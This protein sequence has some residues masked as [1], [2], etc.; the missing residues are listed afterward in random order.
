MRGVS[1]PS[2]SDVKREDF[3]R[4]LVLV[5]PFVGKAEGGRRLAR[6]RIEDVRKDGRGWYTSLYRGVM[7]YRLVTACVY[8]GDKDKALMYGRNFESRVSMD[9]AFT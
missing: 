9:A 6:P 4:R 7:L 3:S 1:G 8:M 2:K 5:S